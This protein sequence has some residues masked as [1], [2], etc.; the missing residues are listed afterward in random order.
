ML[1]QDYKVN[2]IQ[3]ATESVGSYDGMS[4]NDASDASD[5]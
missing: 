1:G 3:D 4:E 5:V 2:Y